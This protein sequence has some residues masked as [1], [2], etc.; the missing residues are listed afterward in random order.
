MA[1]SIGDVQR[2]VEP[3]GSAGG[4]DPRRGRVGLL[5][6]GIG[7]QRAGQRLA[8][9][10]RPPRARP[11]AARRGRGWGSKLLLEAGPRLLGLGADQ[12]RPR[13]RRAAA[14]PAR[15]PRCSPAG[16]R[17]GWCG[18]ERWT[19]GCPRAGSGG[20]AAPDRSPP[21]WRRAGGRSARDR[22][23]GL[24]ESRS[25]SQVRGR[26]EQCQGSHMRRPPLRAPRSRPRR[27]ASVA[28][29]SRL[30]RAAA[31]AASG[32]YAR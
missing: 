24:A 9:G 13:P 3:G 31:N 12:A 5:G 20:A 10:A 18:R 26:P 16:G 32:S 28:E 14:A 21:G 4:R 1:A 15:S 19:G 2:G 29:G 11:G 6:V 22:S 25:V 30:A 27:S 8:S 17:G 23:R 7:P